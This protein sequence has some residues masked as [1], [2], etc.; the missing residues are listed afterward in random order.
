MEILHQLPSANFVNLS[1]T[2]KY[3]IAELETLNKSIAGQNVLALSGRQVGRVT[4]LD[5]AGPWWNGN[6]PNERLSPDDAIF[7]DAI[8]TDGSMLGYGD[9]LADADFYPNGG[10]ASQNG[11]GFLESKYRILIAL[12]E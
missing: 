12:S 10:T 4:G 6:S 11:C 9:R 7:V 5:P 8:H 2:P 1:K 3:V